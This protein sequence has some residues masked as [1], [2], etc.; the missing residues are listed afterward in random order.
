[1][2]EIGGKENETGIEIGKRDRRELEKAKVTDQVC[3][4]KRELQ[5][6]GEK[7]TLERKRKSE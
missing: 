3:K 6:I 5:I 4:R 7:N 2:A 1:M